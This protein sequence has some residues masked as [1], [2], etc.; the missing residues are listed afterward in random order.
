[1]QSVRYGNHYLRISECSCSLFPSLCCGR[2]LPSCM[3]WPSSKQVG[4]LM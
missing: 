3:R 4:S 2:R 1:M